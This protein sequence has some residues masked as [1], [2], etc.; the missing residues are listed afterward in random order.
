MW[1]F[2]CILLFSTMPPVDESS[3]FVEHNDHILIY[4]VER[5]SYNSSLLMDV[6]YKH[7]IWV[8][9]GI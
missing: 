4:S 5:H 3:C 8:S 9:Y 1:V 6:D 2:S 7:Y